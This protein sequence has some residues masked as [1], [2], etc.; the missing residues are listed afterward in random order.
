[1]FMSPDVTVDHSKFEEH[2]NNSSLEHKLKKKLCLRM[3]CE[4]AKKDPWDQ[5]DITKLYYDFNRKGSV[6]K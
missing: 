1:M 3:S 6:D 2:L 5:T 4:N